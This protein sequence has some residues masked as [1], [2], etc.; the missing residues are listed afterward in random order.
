MPD[1]FKSLHETYKAISSRMGIE[2]MKEQ[3]ADAACSHIVRNTART[4]VIA[5]PAEPSL[6]DPP[7]PLVLRKQPCARLH[8]PHTT[9]LRPTSCFP[10]LL[11][12]GAGGQGPPHLA[13][14]VALPALLC[15]EARAHPAP[16][17]ARRA[18][19]ARGRQ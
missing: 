4:R 12:F 10:P 5:P 2:A 3:V 7:S 11:F 6:C 8:L 17:L 19:R 14:V 1:I 15:D 13:G 16:R 9:S 18:A